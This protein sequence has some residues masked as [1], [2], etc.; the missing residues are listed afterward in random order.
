MSI[1]DS[2][3]T[4][5]QLTGFL[6]VADEG[7]FSAAG[8][9]LGRVQSAVSYAVAQLELSLGTRLFDRKGRTPTLTTAGHR[10]AAEA[11]LVLA[12]A[13]ELTECAAQLR[14]GIEPELRVVVD[15]AY[16]H[17]RLV[18]VCTTFRDRFPMTM[19]RLEVG[20]LGDAIAVVARGDADLGACN[21]TGDSPAELTLTYL[22]SVHIVPVCAADHPLARLKA[23]QRSAV[24]AQH[25]QIVHSERSASITA[26]Q[27]VIAT[28]TWRVTDLATKAELICRGIGWGSLPESFATPFLARGALV[29]L[30]PERWPSAGHAVWIHAAVRKEHTL[31]R[32]AQ[33]FRDALRFE[34]PP[35]RAISSR[36]R[37]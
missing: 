27:G 26:D 8:R 31:G 10:L 3:Y 30:Q 18:T 15:A 33:W 23:P 21:F 35:A 16:P 19:L 12:Q 5:D 9:R 4:L 36:R 13:R 37:R 14:G 7:S 25:T 1:A 11:R 20:L 32:A 22:G 6:A 17:D 29:R 28:R 34:E 2:P 24:M